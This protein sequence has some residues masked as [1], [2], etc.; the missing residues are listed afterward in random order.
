MTQHY[1][2]TIFAV[3]D[4]LD[5]EISYFDETLESLLSDSTTAE[6]VQDCGSTVAVYEFKGLK[7]VVRT[8]VLEDVPETDAP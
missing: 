6:I 3:K 7:R 4:P 8:V 5:E 1:P 2:Q